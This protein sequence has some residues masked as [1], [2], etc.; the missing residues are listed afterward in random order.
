MI[1]LGLVPVL[2]HVFKKYRIVTFQQYNRNIITQG[3][4]LIWTS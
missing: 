2:L 3:V 4:L 1:P